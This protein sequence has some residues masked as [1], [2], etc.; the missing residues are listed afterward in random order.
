MPDIFPIALPNFRLRLP[1]DGPLI[2][3]TRWSSGGQSV[4]TTI[5]ATPDDSES[6][7]AA[8][9]LLAYLDVNGDRQL[10]GIPRSQLKNDPD[11]RAPYFNGSLEISAADFKEGK[12]ELEVLTLHAIAKKAQVYQ[13]PDEKS[14]AEGLAANASSSKYDEMRA[15]LDVRLKGANSLLIDPKP[16]SHSF[17]DRSDRSLDEAL[18]T[19][20]LPPVKTDEAS[21]KLIATTCRY[22]GF[23]F[24]TG[25]IDG[26]S[27]QKINANHQ[28]ASALMLLGDQIYADATASLFDNLTTVEKFQER[29]HA[30]FRSSG[31]ATAVRSI[32]TYM[33]GDDHEFS[34]SWSK[35][36]DQLQDLL[37]SAACQSYGIY[38]V[39]HS[40]FRGE[41][42]KPPCDYAFNVGPAGVYVMDTLSNRDTTVPGMEVIVAN[43][44]LGDF[45]KWLKDS[46]TPDFVILA[47]GGVVAPGFSRALDAGGATDVHR[48]QGLE[49]WQ[50]FNGQ[51]IKLLNIIAASGKKVLLLSGDYHCAAQA[52]I[53]DSSGREIA[54]AAV[55][56]PAYAPMRYVNA[57]AA[58]LA[59]TEFTAG[60]RIDLDRD[61]ERLKDGSGF[62]VVT[63]AN[64][65]WRVEF[66]TSAIAD[67]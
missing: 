32:P 28:G 67:I 37:F 41:L 66:D 65:N 20:R 11:L 13:A 53:K 57:S 40:P 8:G 31:F 45:E 4:L 35:P 7:P 50:A 33:T 6:D 19:L 21:F 25:R 46:K 17:E 42:E 64:G 51:R 30:L 36:D 23:A 18:V 63:L 10:R 38:Q 56:P 26:A 14:L 55:V 22:P 34:N 3:W 24:E 43:A 52:S 60:F 27:Y 2:G 44:Q 47:T 48:A 9:L 58:G 61:P 39:S 16:S 29:Y 59:T 5:F 15:E 1:K 49:N 62:A 54:M 12:I